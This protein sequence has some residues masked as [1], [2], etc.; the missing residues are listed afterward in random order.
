MKKMATRLKVVEAPGD[1]P[2]PT[3]PPAFDPAPTRKRLAG[4]TAERQRNFIDILSLTGSVGEASAA[5]GVSSRSAYRLRNRAGA[6]SF[7]KAWD[8][9]L[10]LSVTRLLALAFDRAINGR[11]ERFYKD[12]ELVME[13]RLPSDRLLT[14]LIAHLD[15]SRF[16]GPVRQAALAGADP[17]ALAALALPVLAADLADVDPDDCDCEPPAFIDERSGEMGSDGAVDHLSG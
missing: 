3:P 8:M 17:R 1:L 16:G 6:E 13:R 14:W 4:W 10:Q 2:T 5:A 11:V 9:A 7:A 12:G 15:P